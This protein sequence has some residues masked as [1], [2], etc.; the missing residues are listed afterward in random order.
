[1]IFYK[2][3]IEKSETLLNQNG[4]LYF[5]SHSSRINILENMLKINNFKRIIIKEDMFGKK[6]M[7]SAQK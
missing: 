5:E 6:R 2:K 1:M 4:V 3:I 7:I